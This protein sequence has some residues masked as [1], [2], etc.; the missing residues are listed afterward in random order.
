MDKSQSILQFQ[1]LIVLYGSRWHITSP[2]SQRCDALP[3]ICKFSDSWILITVH[4]LS[5][6]VLQR[7]KMARAQGGS[8]DDVAKPSPSTKDAN[9]TSAP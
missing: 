6:S 5:A 2:A 8:I 9:R 4:I 1:L 7:A 3:L